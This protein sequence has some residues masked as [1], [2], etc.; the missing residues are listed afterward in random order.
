[1][2]I[3][4]LIVVCCLIAST[5]AVVPACI[6]ANYCRGCDTSIATNCTRCHNYHMGTIGAKF[7]TS[8]N[9]VNSLTPIVGCKIYYDRLTTAP[10]STVAGSCVMCDKEMPIVETTTAGVVS[11]TCEKDLPTGCTKIDNCHQPKCTTADAGVNYTSTCVQCEKGKGASAID[12][13]AATIP[14]NCEVS[15]W[16]GGA[17]K[18]EYASKDY[19]MDSTWL[20]PVAYTTDSA[21]QAL[22]A[23]SITQCQICWDG[24]YWDTTVCKLSTQLIGAAF[25]FVVGLFIN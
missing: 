14:A 17:A 24:Y 4:I 7:L 9:C 25:L 13:C 16:I 21:C 1:M 10:T 8:N 5:F 19:A 22:M 15:A 6:A 11:V 20:T 2:K 3:S 23:G 18:C 12:A